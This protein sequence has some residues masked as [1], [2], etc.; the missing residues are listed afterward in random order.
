MFVSDSLI[1]IHMQ[2][3]AGSHIVRLLS[4]IFAGTVVGKHN[5]ASSAILQSGARVISSMRNPW[6]WYLSL[7]TYGV[8]G[9]GAFSERLTKK[10]FGYP[11]KS[12]F[13][14]AQD[15]VGNFYSEWVKDTDRWRETYACGDDA[16]A[17]RSW[18]NMIHDPANGR[19]LG[20]G[21]S[22]TVLPKEFGFMTHR[23]LSLCCSN[24]VKLKNPH[25]IKGFEDLKAF[26][27]DSCYVDRFILQ[28]RLEADFCEVVSSVRPLN[29][30]EIDLVYSGQK[31]NASS[32]ALALADYYDDQTIDLVG[33]RERLLVE[34]FGYSF[35]RAADL[36]TE[37][38]TTL[39]NSIHK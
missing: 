18:L 24:T 8:Q 17:F 34:K 4:Q 20:E 35:N 13:H 19:V 16:N 5:A 32:R 30:S 2:K 3:T 15:V 27:L 11:L 12:T 31:T 22:A 37:N 21:Y 9:K 26:D 38:E 39:T 14:N 28:E 36:A 23:Y 6:D 1:Y 25:L 29:Q 33:Q 7:W 10:K